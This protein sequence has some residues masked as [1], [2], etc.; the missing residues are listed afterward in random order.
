MN[1]D[2][3]IENALIA[4]KTVK[5]NCTIDVAMRVGK[6]KIA[7]LYID[8]LLKNKADLFSK[9]LWI[10]DNS[11]EKD[12]D[13]AE[14]AKLWN[15]DITKVDLIHWRS[16]HTVNPSDY[17][18]VIFN[19]CQNITPTLCGYLHGFK[20]AKI[21]GM[22]GTYPKF[23]KANLLKELGLNKI[24]FKYDINEASSD[25]IT[26]DYSVNIVEI[27]MGI[28]KD[29]LVQYDGGTFLVSEQSTYDNLSKKIDEAKTSS[30]ERFLRLMRMKAIN[31]FDSKIRYTKKLILENSRKNLKTLIFAQDNEHAKKIGN[32]IYSSHT[33]DKMLQKFE[34]GEIS[35]LILIN[36]GGTGYTYNMPINCVI[37]LAVHSQNTIL[38]KIARGSVNNK[39]DKLK[40]IIPISKN[41]VQKNWVESALK[42]I[43]KNKIVYS[44]LNNQ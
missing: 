7:L 33:D 35:Y 43:Q 17:F 18:L 6:T 9:V 29:I 28:E 20:R 24:A 13:V 32:N 2:Q 14:E 12:K 26:S 34:N 10:C 27:P 44:S 15:I 16:I 25:S 19:E 23:E 38:Q 31:K 41:T 36:K 21:V 39:S 5:G 3:V 8:F 11:K 30:Q 37:L 4:L 40:V 22:T 42:D 1:R